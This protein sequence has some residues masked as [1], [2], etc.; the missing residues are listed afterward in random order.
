MRC[1]FI[2]G[3]GF[4]CHEWNCINAYLLPHSFFLEFTMRNALFF[5]NIGENVSMNYYFS[6]SL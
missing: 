2:F 3:N 1:C 4:E 5:E 6:L